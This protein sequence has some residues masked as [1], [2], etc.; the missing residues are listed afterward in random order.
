MGRASLFRRFTDTNVYGTGSVK[1]RKTRHK[2]PVDVRIFLRCR[3]AHGA[4]E[5]ERLF[6]GRSSVGLK[7]IVGALLEAVRRLR[8][9]CILSVF[10]LSIFALIGLQI[11]QGTLKQKCIKI[12]ADVGWFENL[13][14]AVEDQPKNAELKAELLNYTENRGRSTQ[15]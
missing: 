7:T 14:R 2:V 10:V 5:I 6:D 8:D 11:Y 3:R 4:A 12:P 13:T 15:P 1:V 9:V